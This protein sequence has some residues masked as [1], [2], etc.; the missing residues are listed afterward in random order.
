MN[1]PVDEHGNVHFTTTL[2]ALIRES[3]GIKMRPGAVGFFNDVPPYT[4]QKFKNFIL[5]NSKVH[6]ICLFSQKCDIF[7]EKWRVSVEEMNEAD[8][9]LREILKKVWPLHAKKSVVDLALP[10][11]DCLTFCIC[12]GHRPSVNE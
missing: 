3:L 10:T 7:I 11:N 8:E 9:E 5:K 1:M 12:S 4:C 6:K 2:F